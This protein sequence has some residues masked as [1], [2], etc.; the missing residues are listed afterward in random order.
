MTLFVKPTIKDRV[1]KELQKICPCFEYS[2]GEKKKLK[3]AG[4]TKKQS[5]Y[6]IK[7]QRSVNNTTF[8][9]CYC[10]AKVGCNLIQDVV[11]HKGKLPIRENKELAAGS[12]YNFRENYLEFN[13][14]KRAE[15]DTD[16][17]KKRAKSEMQL[18]HELVHALDDLNK[19]IPKTPTEDQA[20]G[21]EERAVRATNQI[22]KEQ[23][24]GYH[25][26]SHKGKPVPKP[27]KKEIDDANRWQCECP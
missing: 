26:T 1:L 8:C 24:L 10:K 21:F 19:K 7:V 20:R 5:W 16:K 23:K 9:K 17:G 3:L 2:L 6:R 18:A 11:S 4:D 15:I 13:R 14:A 12:F 27:Q 25:R 22:R